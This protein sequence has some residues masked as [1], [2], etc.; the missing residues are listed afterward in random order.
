M[1]ANKGKTVGVLCVDPS[2]PFNSGALL[3]DRVRMNN[4]HNHPNVFI[5]SCLEVH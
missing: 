5:R 2:S 4:W 3:G 1:A